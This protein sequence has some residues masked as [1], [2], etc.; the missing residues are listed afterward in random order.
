MLNAIRGQEDIDKIWVRR[1]TFKKGATK[2]P[3][4]SIDHFDVIIRP[5]DSVESSKDDHSEIEAEIFDCE[6]II[7]ASNDELKSRDYLRNRLGIPLDAVVAYVQLGAGQINDIESDIAITLTELAK[8][9]NVYT[10][11]GESM[12]GSPISFEGPRVRF[13]RDYPNSINF[14]AFDF[15]VTA[16]GY[17]SYHEMIHFGLPSICYPNLN[18]GMDDQLARA[19]VAEDAGA[20]I[21]LTEI[22]RK[23]V[24]SAI[25]KIM[26]PETRQ[27][28]KMA[29]KKLTRDN[30][31]DQVAEYL[32][33]VLNN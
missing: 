9:D 19:K 6:P 30:G 32:A 29:T 17:N 22:N 11:V 2:I 26:N 15:A 33:K 10:V 5:S 3:V 28:M 7:F 13:L 27:R 20:M 23:S 24:S 4:D 25:E 18:T 21:V 14:N 1:G 12:L 31:A 16:C 8:H